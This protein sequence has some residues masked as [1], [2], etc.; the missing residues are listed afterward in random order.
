L[1]RIGIIENSA[2]IPKVVTTIIYKKAK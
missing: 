2:D 1:T